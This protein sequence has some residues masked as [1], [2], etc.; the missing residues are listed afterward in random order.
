M[1]ELIATAGGLIVG[2]GLV[3]GGITAL[4]CGWHCGGKITRRDAEI[5]AKDRLI[6]SQDKALSERASTIF[7][8]N[9]ALGRAAGEVAALTF[10]RDEL[11]AALSLIKAKRSARIAA[12]NRTR[13]INRVAR[14]AENA[15]LEKKAEQA[16]AR[17]TASD[18]GWIEWAGGEC[19]VPA[20]IQHQVR[21]RDGLVSEVDDCPETW[22]WDH[23]DGEGDIIAYRIADKPARKTV[24]VIGSGVGA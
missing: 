8:R 7:K 6:S 18:D 5:E 2:G 1:I 9:A 10:E 17:K 24:K 3:G 19:P 11:K 15:R 20:G 23:E 12:G 4:A 22:S 16:F 21:L 14:E 13:R